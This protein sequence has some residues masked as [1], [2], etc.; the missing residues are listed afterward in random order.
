M[1]PYLI[2]SHKHY[3]APLAWRLS[4]EGAEVTLI[5]TKKRYQ[6]AWEGRLDK[7]LKGRDIPLEDPNLKPW[8]EA[9]LLGENR[10]VTDLTQA[11][12]STLG[13]STHLL[14]TLKTPKPTPDNYSLVLGGW[15]SQAHWSLLHWYLPEW[16]LFPGGGGAEVI[17]GGTVLRGRA[18]PTEVLDPLTGHLAQATFTGL[19]G[20][21]VRYDKASGRLEPTGYFHAGWDDWLHWELALCEVTSWASLLNGDSL[22]PDA[23]LPP[24]TVGLTVTQPPWPS[25]GQP[26]PPRVELALGPETTK[27]LFLHDV[28]VDGGRVFTAGCDGLV[29]VARGVGR[30]LGR[31]R[32]GALATAG[33][34]RFPERQARGDVASQVEAAVGALEGLGW[35]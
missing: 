11:P 16:G 32:A 8:V 7:P 12:H 28:V 19:V 15:F 18:Y 3:L 21:G 20:V 24:F 31:A 2:L 35:W 22:Q 26:V 33:A 6:G 14:F 30:S 23:A 5:I 29:G 4:R 9:A 34:L 1:T 17:A 27:T 25:V 13:G 10:V